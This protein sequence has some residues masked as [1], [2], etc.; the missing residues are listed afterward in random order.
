[1]DS[2]L[3]N[4]GETPMIRLSRL[5]AAEGLECELLAKCDFY[6]A[7]GSVKVNNAVDNAA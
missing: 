3:D 6:S 2:A 7:G 1:M 4:I 5:A